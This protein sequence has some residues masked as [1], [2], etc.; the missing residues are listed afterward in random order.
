MFMN[1]KEINNYNDISGCESTD[2]LA[3][4]AEEIRN[5][6][7]NFTNLNG[8]H[9]GSNLGVVELTIALLSRYS[10]EKYIYLFDTGHQS[11]V[12]KLLTDRKETFETIN[13][14]NGISNF[15]EIS[16]SDFDYISTGHSG[17][18]IGYAMGYSVGQ[19]EKKVISIVG[20]A[21]FYGSYTNAGLL[22]LIKSENKTITIVNDNNEA[23]GRNSIKIKNLRSYVEG[24]G[25]NYVYCDDGHDFSKLF[26]AFNECEKYNNHVIIHVITKKGFKYNGE[27][28][29][30]FNHTIEEN[31][32]N[33]FQKK[34][35]ELI[36]SCFNKNS[37][38]IC[39][40]M[41]NASGFTK[42]WENYPKNVIDCG[43]NEEL[44][45]LVA[46]SLANLGKTVFISV[47]STFFQRMFDQLT[48]DIFRNNLSI[49]FLIDRAGI[50]YTTGI[51]HHGIYD[52][53]LI[54]NF[55]ETII[56]CPATSSD[57]SN[58]KNLIVNNKK[59]L[60]IRYEKAEVINLNYNENQNDQGWV[61][62]I[63]NKNNSSTIITYGV[64]LKEFYDIIT[65][66]NYP[67]NLINARFINPIDKKLLEKHKENKIYVYE[68]VI[69]KNNLFTNIDLF[70][71]KKDN[72][73][74]YALNRNDIHHGSK[75]D[76]LSYLKMD[77]ED[78]VNII[79]KNN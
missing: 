65:N 77:P 2:T 36:E 56:Y 28:E 31:K 73:Y 42:L 76:L 64:I 23:I 39:P 21:A 69:N 61:E 63:Y 68:Q 53:S 20:D 66:N 15:Q 8:G 24:I 5:F 35:P 1:W 12:Y 62:V 17:T 52:V 14:F 48:H 70:Y 25:F 57:I 45:A 72:I 3:S 50:N 29:L 11:H 10:P 55:N 4:L 34:I 44:T 32:N 46:S 22:N 16:E 59:Q 67:I 27:K 58:I 6:L 43:I 37:Y 26:D 18:A 19:S 41:I 9:I 51:S 33:T 49:I 75:K 79:L 38:L 74:S 60:F 78:I 54:Q 71:K 13:K 30:T 40:A 47:Y 7:I